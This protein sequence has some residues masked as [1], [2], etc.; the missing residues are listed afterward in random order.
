MMIDKTPFIDKKIASF[1][2]RPE[3]PFKPSLETIEIIRYKYSK[4]F[5][6]K[7]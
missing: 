7:F 3:N 5:M 2:Q 6:G 4:H 1:P